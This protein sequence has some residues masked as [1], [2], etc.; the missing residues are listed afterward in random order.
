MERLCKDVFVLKERRD[1]VLLSKPRVLLALLE[2]FVT[3]LGQFRS[4]D[5]VTPR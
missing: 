4:L 3:C 5:I 2:I 1:K